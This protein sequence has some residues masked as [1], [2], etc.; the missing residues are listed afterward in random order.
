MF[1][2][3]INNKRYDGVTLTNQLRMFAARAVVYPIKIMT[4]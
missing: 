3:G 1:D 4:W 2:P